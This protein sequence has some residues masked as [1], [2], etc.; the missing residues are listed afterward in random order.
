MTAFIPEVR[1]C[2]ITQTVRLLSNGTA[3]VLLFMRVTNWYGSINVLLITVTHCY[4]HPS[5]HELKRE[6][7]KSILIT[8]KTDGTKISVWTGSCFN[9]NGSDSRNCRVFFSPH[10]LSLHSKTDK[11]RLKRQGKCYCLQQQMRGSRPWT[12]PCRFSFLHQ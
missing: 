8:K 5:L 2:D 11:S 6:R 3:L 4:R 1:R 10:W 9:R 7:P 12:Q